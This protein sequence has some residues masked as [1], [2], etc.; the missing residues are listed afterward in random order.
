MIFRLL[1]IFV[2]GHIPLQAAHVI[3][4]I[5][6]YR[7]IVQEIVGST[8]TVGIMVP[9]GADMHAFEPSPRQMLE[10]S[11][12]DLWFRV[13]EP[14][15]KKALEAL[16]AYN[17]QLQIIDL[18]KHVLLI[19]ESTC[20][21]CSHGEDLHFWLSPSTVKKQAAQITS[22]LSSCYPENASLYQENFN[23]LQNKLDN[24][25]ASIKK[26]LA[27]LQ[28]RLL[29]VSHPSFAY[30]GRDY[31]LQQYSIEFEGKDP[32]P[33]QLT[34]V[35]NFAKEHHVKTVFAEKQTGTKG[36]SLV[37]SQIGANLIILDPFATPYEEMMKILTQQIINGLQ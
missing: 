19:Y 33:K 34:T 20:P 24:L 4:S 2:L 32:S 12:A 36:A 7:S 3:V 1:Y 13:G 22:T 23:R 25:D 11:Q 15:E 18:R 8:A 17:S 10:I 14:F 26:A 5:A 6:P 16:K 35:L 21:N 28:N 27:S 29:F 9:P 30:Y 31:N 37:A